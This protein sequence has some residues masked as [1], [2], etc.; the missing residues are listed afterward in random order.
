MSAI[1][2][3]LAIVTV[4]FNAVMLQRAIDAGRV[5]AAASNLLVIV[6]FALVAWHLARRMR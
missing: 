1:L 2:F 5:A 3:T 6:T 4:C